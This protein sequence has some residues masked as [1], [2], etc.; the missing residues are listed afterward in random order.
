MS[1]KTENKKLQPY[2]SL[3]GSLAL[4]IGSAIGWGSLV[5]TSSNYLGQAGPIGSILG[6]LIGACLMIK[7]KILIIVMK[8]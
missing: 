1:E 6:L 8:Y 7:E 5:V 4:S 3:A 2:L